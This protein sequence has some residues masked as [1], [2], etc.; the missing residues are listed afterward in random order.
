MTQIT[1]ITL[2]KAN[3]VEAAIQEDIAD[4]QQAAIFVEDVSIVSD[5]QMQNGTRILAE[6]KNKYK[7]I[8]T[9]KKS[10][11]QPLKQVVKELDQFFKPALD[12]LKKAEAIVKDKISAC[13]EEREV[14]RGKLLQQVRHKTPEQ[15]NEVEEI[16]KQADALAIPKIDGLSVREKW[17]GDLV[18]NQAAVQWAMDNGRAELLTIDVK[19]L[20]ALTIAQDGKVDIPGWKPYKKST[21]VITAAKVKN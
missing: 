15:K 20:E 12:S 13:V 9:K 4:V 17:T 8:E 21:V 2:P 6:L 1:S 14:A 19:S 18:S 3:D 7:E 11:T 10:F 5:E 16:I